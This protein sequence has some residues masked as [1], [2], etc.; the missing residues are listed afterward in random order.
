M[1]VSRKL[2][3][4]S[5][6]KVWKSL[7]FLS[8]SFLNNHAYDLFTQFHTCGLF[9][10]STMTVENLWLVC[11]SCGNRKRS[12]TW[13]G[14]ESFF[15]ADY[16]YEISTLRLGFRNF[17]KIA[18]LAAKCLSCWW[19]HET[20]NTYSLILKSRNMINEKKGWNS[21]SKICDAWRNICSGP[22]NSFY[23]KVYLASA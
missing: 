2:F 17:S 9:L 13:N 23:R 20:R 4:Q 19:L 6:W 15:F 8:V 7:S 16:S 11:L 12:V 1:L 3:L 5:C 21:L 14:W 10:Y 18:K 22:F